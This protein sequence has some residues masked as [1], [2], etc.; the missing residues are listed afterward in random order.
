MKNIVI[1]NMSRSIEN[2]KEKGI[3]IE[4]PE[5]P[6]YI[7]EITV[8]ID[9][10]HIHAIRME[11]GTYS[12]HLLPYSS[13]DSPLELSKAVIDKVPQFGNRLI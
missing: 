9:G 10:K 8:Q 13:Y 1:I 6:N 11:D 3:I 12:C 4:E 5:D 7:G 2:Y